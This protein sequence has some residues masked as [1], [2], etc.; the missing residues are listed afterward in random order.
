M[1]IN[2]LFKEPV[3]I[4]LCQKFVLCFG[5]KGLHDTTLFSKQDMINHHTV[6]QISLLLDDLKTYYLPCKGKVYLSNITQQSCITILRQLVRLHGKTLNST[7]KYVAKRKETFYFLQEKN[8][9][10]NIKQTQ[11]MV[12]VD[13][14]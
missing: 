4:E 10:K 6:T 9:S 11:E 3:P 8:Q 1:K 5:L 2:Q 7:Q 13:F 14:S 12:R